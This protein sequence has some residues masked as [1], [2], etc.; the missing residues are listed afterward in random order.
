MSKLV[1]HALSAARDCVF[2]IFA[3][4]PHPQLEDAPCRGD[5]DPLITDLKKKILIRNTEGFISPKF[6]SICTYAVLPSLSSLSTRARAHTH[7][8]LGNF[9]LTRCIAYFGRHHCTVTATHCHPLLVPCRR[10][11]QIA[12][13]SLLVSHRKRCCANDDVGVSQLILQ[14]TVLSI[15]HRLRY[16]FCSKPEVIMC[17]FAF[18]A[19]V[20]Q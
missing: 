3:A 19:F 2:N 8:L 13:L 18:E 6:V 4:T 9:S 14:Y 11:S 20:K 15:L 17:D 1:D 12:L 10:L 7:T 16:F 5:R